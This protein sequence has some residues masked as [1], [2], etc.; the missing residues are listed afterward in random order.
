MELMEFDETRD[1]EGKDL[2]KNLGFS[3]ICKW[4]HSFYYFSEIICYFKD[5]LCKCLDQY[6]F[7]NRYDELRFMTSTFLLYVYIF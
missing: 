6:R 4:N 3:A 5:M 7:T 2:D 1:R